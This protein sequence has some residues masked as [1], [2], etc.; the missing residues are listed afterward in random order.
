MKR[1]Y[2]FLAILIFI[3]FYTLITNSYQ[4]P[5]IEN[6]SPQEMMLEISRRIIQA[7]NAAKHFQHPDKIPP[8][9][10]W[11]CD[12]Q[13]TGKAVLGEMLKVDC[14]KPNSG[15]NTE[16]IINKTCR[17]KPLPSTTWNN[18]NKNRFLKTK[19]LIERENLSEENIYIPPTVN[20]C[21]QGCII[22]DKSSGGLISA[23]SAYNNWKCDAE[24]VRNGILTN[25]DI[26]SSL[27]SSDICKYDTDCIWCE[28]TGYT[29]VDTRTYSEIQGDVKKK[30]SLY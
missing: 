1:N 28:N 7:R 6:F 27:S 18:K 11:L 30:E 5:V 10:I 17:Y 26:T 13:N 4:K 16:E 15:C 21:K 12:S 29:P 2:L 25:P 8:E 19:K 9:K 22:A 20:T 24:S 3:T 14:S 23:S